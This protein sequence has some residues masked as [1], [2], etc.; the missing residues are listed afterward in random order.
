M[1]VKVKC[2]RCGKPATIQSSSEE[3]ESVKKL[4]CTCN[5]TEC[6]HAFVM[7]LSFSHTLSPS[8]MDFPA[9]FI[10]RLKNATQIQQQKIFSIL[11]PAS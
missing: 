9:D 11:S 1:A 5:N 4:Y 6:G 10:N 8:A 2:N 3:S 7:D